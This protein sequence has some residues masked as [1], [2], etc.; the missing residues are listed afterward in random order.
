MPVGVVGTITPFNFPLN[1]VAHK[2]AP[3][4]A[5]GC[6][7]VLKPADQTPLSAIALAE[8]LL[9]QCARTRGV[10]QR[11]DGRGSVVGQAI[12]DN[13]AVEMV[14]LTGSPEVGWAIRR[15]GA[16]VEDLVLAQLGVADRFDEGR[17]RVS[18]WRARPR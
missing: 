10:D 15:D 14:T 9:D 8:V 7:V 18:P 3:A 1:L 5:A 2:V 6:A 13:P 17:S 11:G 16:E 12:V 4:I